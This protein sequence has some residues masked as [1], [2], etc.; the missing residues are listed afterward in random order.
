MS[1]STNLAG[2]RLVPPVESDEVAMPSRR[3]PDGSII[4]GIVEDRPRPYLTVLP[5]GRGEGVQEPDSS[6]S[7]T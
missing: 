5:V 3:M 6:D 4:F 2:L 7:D 1:D